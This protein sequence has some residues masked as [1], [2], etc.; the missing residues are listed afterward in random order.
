MELRRKMMSRLVVELEVVKVNGEWIRKG[1]DGRGK[2]CWEVMEEWN[3]EYK[4]NW[5]D[6]IINSVN[7]E[8]K[9]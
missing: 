2:E 9:S 7:E 8:R 6:E 3:E 5:I 1:L 4:D